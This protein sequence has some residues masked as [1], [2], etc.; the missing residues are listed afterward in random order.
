MW[1]ELIVAV[2]DFLVNSKWIII[3][4]WRITSEHLENEYSKGP[5][6]HK[7][8]VTL[9]LNDFRSQIFRCP[10]ECIGTIIYDFSEAKI[11]Y[12]YMSFFVNQ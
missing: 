8:I 10:A 12:F 1:R 9:G 7:F 5:P 2:H 11:C 4:K 6:I 3:I